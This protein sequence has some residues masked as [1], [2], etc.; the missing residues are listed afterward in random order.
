MTFYGYKKFSVKK[1]VRSFRDLEVYQKTLGASVIIAKDLWPELEKLAGRSQA[2]RAGIQFR[3]WDAMINCS[4]TIPLFLGEA[5]SLRFG[6]H[7]KA[8]LLLENAMAGCNK[9]IIYLEQILGIYRPAADI[10]LPSGG[11]PRKAGSAGIDHD[12]LDDLIKKYSD[13]RIKIFRL[14]KSWQRFEPPRG[15]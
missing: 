13:V 2:Q 3:H 15:V 11:K 9:M 14:E 4:M 5:H 10:A 1:P 7:K 8:L 12:L 6:D